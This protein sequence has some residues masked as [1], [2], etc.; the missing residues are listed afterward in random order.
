MRELRWLLGGL[1]LL[2][3][4]EVLE[5]GFKF[6]EVHAVCD[7]P[8]VWAARQRRNNTS[9][10]S[11][12]MCEAISDAYDFGWGVVTLLVLVTVAR[13]LHSYIRMLRLHR[14]RE[15]ATAANDILA[16][17]R[18]SEPR[19]STSCSEPSNSGSEPSSA[20]IS[21]AAS[22]RHADEV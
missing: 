7:A 4:L 5:M 11:E 18:T 22:A 2:F 6:A 13:V 9:A 16:V 21:P 20:S 3:L 12:R 10:L 8:E 19:G 1:A 14:A 15:R 17:G